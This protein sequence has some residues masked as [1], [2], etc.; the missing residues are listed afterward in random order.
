MISEKQQEIEQYRELETRIQEV[1]D[2]NS[3]LHKV[4]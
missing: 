3:H 2:Q 1:A 4:F